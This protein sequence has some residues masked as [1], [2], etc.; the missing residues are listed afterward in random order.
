M[1]LFMAWLSANLRGRKYLAVG[2]AWQVGFG[3]CAN[4]ISSNV[5]L[6]EEA[7]F[8]QTGFSNGLSWTIVGMGLV[9]LAVVLMWRKNQTRKARMAMMSDMEKEEE[10]QR[11]F[12]FLL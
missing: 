3:N 11:T 9:T 10:E 7:P 2:M 1:A 4:F 12:K 6:A 5:F 8:Y